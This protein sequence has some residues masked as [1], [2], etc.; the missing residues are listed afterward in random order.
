[1]LCTLDGEVVEGS[2]AVERTAF[3][4]HAHLEQACR[5]QLLAMQSGQ[6][7][8]RSLTKARPAMEVA[9]SVASYGDVFVTVIKRVLDEEEPDYNS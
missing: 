1:M 2:G 7:W 3:S 8:R 9:H 4:L 6:P 5:L